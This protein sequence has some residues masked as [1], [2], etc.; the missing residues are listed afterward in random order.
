MY[1]I[2][3]I[4]RNATYIFRKFDEVEYTSW[5]MRAQLHYNLSKQHC[6]V[7][8]PQSDVAVINENISSPCAT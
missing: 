7:A 8:A 4:A 1:F 2:R 5:Q 6:S 3:R